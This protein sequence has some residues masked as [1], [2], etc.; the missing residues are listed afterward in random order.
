MAVEN[1]DHTG[2]ALARHILPVSATMVGVCTTLIGLVR[3][4]EVHSG[5]SH[6]DE[7]TAVVALLFLASAMASYISIRYASRPQVSRKCEDFAD[8]VFIV[9]LV[10]IALIGLL[11]AYEVI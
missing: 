4:V 5:P 3:V 10:A 1:T 8:Y 11:F 2:R 7:Y 6:V 9:G